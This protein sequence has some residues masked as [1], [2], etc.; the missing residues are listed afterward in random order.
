MEN[1]Q[2]ET[3]RVGKVLAGFAQRL[4]RQWV[5]DEHFILNLFL[6]LYYRQ[7]DLFSCGGK[8]ALLTSFVFFSI[9]IFRQPTY[10]IGETI[11]VFVLILFSILN[12]T[13]LATFSFN[14]DD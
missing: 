14:G 1:I 6:Y 4:M 2:H 9:L 7:D 12:S 10:L 5:Q 3:T 13:C 11:N 8:K